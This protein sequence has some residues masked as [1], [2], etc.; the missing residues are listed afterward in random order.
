[1]KGCFAGFLIVLCCTLGFSNAFADEGTDSLPNLV[2]TWSG[3]EGK[4]YLKAFFHEGHRVGGI[5]LRITEQDGAYFRGVNAWEHTDAKEALTEF[6]GKRI[7]SAEEPFVGVIG[8]DGKT[9]YIAEHGDTGY[10]H[11]YL[12]G[13]DTMKAVYTESG[14][15][16]LVIRFSL[17][18]K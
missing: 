17:K 13:P 2:G 9:L 1:M 10:I 15:N 3:V 4:A 8:W 5:E 11:A 18:R 7:A 6:E 14:P 12:E 16:A